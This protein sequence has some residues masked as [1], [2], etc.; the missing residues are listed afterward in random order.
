[1]TPTPRGLYAITPDILE[2]DRLA[3]LVARALEGGVDVLQFR[4]KGGEPARREALARRV[5][6]LCDAAGVPMIVNDDVGL[7]IAVEAAGVH[8]GRDDGDPAAIRARIG[9]G[10]LLGVSCY[11][12][13]SRAQAVT[14]IADHVGFG[15]VFASPTK[16]QAVRA[17]LSLFGRAR[18]AGLPAVA[19]GGIDRTNAARAIEA[20]ADAVA[21]ITDLFAN[22]DPADSARVLRRVVHEALARRDDARH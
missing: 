3:D 15:S 16:P 11:D 5:K 14:G 20:G 21:V 18:A 9:P 19:I 7:A 1:M 6:A 22:G 12:D 2:A 13:W 8:A 17:P 10:R 4:V